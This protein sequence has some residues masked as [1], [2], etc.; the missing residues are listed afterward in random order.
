MQN[1]Y[2]QLI[3]FLLCEWGMFLTFAAVVLFNK[4]ID[5]IVDG[6]LRVGK[7]VS[8]SLIAA[9]IFVT[10]ACCLFAAYLGNEGAYFLSFICID[11]YFPLL[12][13]ILANFGLFISSI[14]I[15]F[16]NACFNMW[17]KVG[18]VKKIHSYIDD[19]K[20]FFIS[21]NRIVLLQ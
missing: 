3:S 8:R 4:K 21:L 12:L 6:L 5:E 19:K 20:D 7:R 10:E 9:S 17:N 16:I 18:M 13:F 11:H 14:L 2:Q 15:F 1:V